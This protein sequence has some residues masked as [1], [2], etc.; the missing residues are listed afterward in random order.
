MYR[1]IILQVDNYTIAAG[2]LFQNNL[3]FN[4]S[5]Q[6]QKQKIHCG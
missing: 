5:I 2:L 1:T 4:L 6:Q 3:L